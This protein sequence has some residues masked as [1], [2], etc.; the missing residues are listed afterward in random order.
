MNLITFPPVAMIDT[1]GEDQEKSPY[2]DGSQWIG[3]MIDTRTKSHSCT[4]L[5]MRDE[6]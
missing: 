2:A 4:V 1:R 6:S 3:S 5:V